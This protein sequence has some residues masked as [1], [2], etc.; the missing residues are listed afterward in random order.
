MPDKIKLGILNK[1]YLILNFYLKRLRR[2]FR[3]PHLQ[4]PT[5]KFYIIITITLLYLPFTPSAQQWD[6][7]VLPGTK[8]IEIPF[9][10]ENNF[11][12]V[13]VTFNRLFPLKFIFDTGA[14][15]TILTKREITDLLGLSYEKRFTIFGSDMQ[16][17]LYAYLVRN[18]TLKT[19][20]AEFTNRAILVLED[21]Y[22][23][24]E[25]FAGV[26]ISGI[27]GAD[28]FRRF[29]VEINYRTQKITLHDPE[30]FRAPRGNV[31]QHP[32]E[33]SR[34]KPYFYA[35]THFPNDT[36]I[37]TKLLL[38]TGAG[39]ALLL[40]TDTHPDLHL[41]PHVIKSNI[42][43]GLGGFIE[44]FLGR[45]E[46]LD[47]AGLPFPEVITNFQEF[48]AS[49]DTTYTNGRNGIIGNQLLSR[50]IVTIDYIRGKLYLQPQR[51]YREQFR[52]DRSG[53]VLAASGVRL[54]SYTIYQII[55][56]SPAAEAGLQRGDIIRK[57]NGLPAGF[58]TLGDLNRRLQGRVGKLFRLKV[59]RDG[60]NFVVHFRLRELI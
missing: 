40:Y 37:S 34:H 11:I 32:V 52:F 23:Q 1:S 53:L 47:L 5:M 28:L 7:D 50:F 21:D 15:H 16:S 38:D 56:G 13:N 20:T 33:I 35:C 31:I 57:I 42:G 8:K 48:P 14:E 24:F 9:E 58:F 12:V 26:N 41:P 29:V 30:S 10:Y 39:L 44:G 59:E 45:V 17:E 19:S 36:L 25:Q 2:L 51:H 46:R 43:M 6:L 22:F 27:L 18:I 54:N 3:C 55:D 60:Q 4:Y 49:L